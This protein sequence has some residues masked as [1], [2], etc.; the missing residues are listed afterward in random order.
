MQTLWFI[1]ITLKKC[2]KI[3]LSPGPVL[4]Q[5]KLKLSVTWRIV[6]CIII[7]IMKRYIHKLIYDYAVETMWKKS[8]LFP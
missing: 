7:I 1:I 6:N 4:V 3:S 2:L 5:A 8:V